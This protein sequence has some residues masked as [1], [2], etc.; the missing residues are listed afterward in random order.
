M[1]RKG[2]EEEAEKRKYCG[3]EESSRGVGNME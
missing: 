1:R 2:K 3:S